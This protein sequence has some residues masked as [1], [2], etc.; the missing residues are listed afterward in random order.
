MY[1][2]L[3][4]LFSKVMKTAFDCNDSQKPVTMTRGVKTNNHKII[5]IHPCSNLNFPQ[6]EEYI[7]KSKSE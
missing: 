1:T 7:S 6:T 5:K 2:I 3:L 4:S